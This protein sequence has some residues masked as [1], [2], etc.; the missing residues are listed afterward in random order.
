MIRSWHELRLL[1]A[2]W[3]GCAV[4]GLATAQTGLDAGQEAPGFSLERLDGG[5]LALSDLRGRPV[6]INFWASWC[7]PCR[8]EMPALAQA[9]RAQRAQGLEVVAINLT[10]QERRADIARFVSDLALPFTVLLDVRGRV[11][12]RYRLV[13]LPTTIFLDSAGI[14]RRRHSGP[15]S[16]EDLDAGLRSLAPAGSE[17]R[18]DEPPP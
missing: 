15:L 13:Q 17:R 5:R 8:V 2:A 18:G 4:P 6:L 16:S 11:R 14:I 7:V 1:S 3:V 9:W 12:E 10:D